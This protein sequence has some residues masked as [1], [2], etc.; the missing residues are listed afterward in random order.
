MKGKYKRFVQKLK[1]NGLIQSVVHLKN[2]E[3]EIATFRE[4]GI[5]G[6]TT[7]PVE[8]EMREINRRVDIGVRWSIPGVENLL[9]VK[10]HLA[11]NEP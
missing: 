11:L 4:H 6:Y 1:K 8:R 7:S 10:M 9:L 2:A 5:V 3:P